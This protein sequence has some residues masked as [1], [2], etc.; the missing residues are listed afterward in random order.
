MLFFFYLNRHF[1]HASKIKTF[2]EK[3]EIMIMWLCV[4]FFFSIYFKWVLCWIIC[5]KILFIWQKVLT[6]SKWEPA[7]KKFILSNCDFN[8]IFYDPDLFSIKKLYC[9]ISEFQR[10]T[11]IVLRPPFSTDPAIGCITYVFQ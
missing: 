9:Y 7:I 10:P 1:F 2:F 8:K 4:N 11:I 6:Y 5:P 3:G